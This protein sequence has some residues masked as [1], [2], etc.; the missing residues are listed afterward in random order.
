[1][2]VPREVAESLIRRAERPKAEKLQI[3]VLQNVPENLAEA[4]KKVGQA[5]PEESAGSSCSL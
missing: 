3:G 4:V 1:M 2:R 5:H